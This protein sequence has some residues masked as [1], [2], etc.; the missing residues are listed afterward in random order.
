MRSLYHNLEKS[1]V[2]ELV[3]LRDFSVVCLDEQGSVFPEFAH[4]VSLILYFL[5]SSVSVPAA[6]VFSC[7]CHNTRIT[8]V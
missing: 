1:R 6:A 4:L 5:F 8:E 2:S 3:F 7:D